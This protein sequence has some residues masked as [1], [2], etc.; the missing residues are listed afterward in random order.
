[1]YKLAH[2]HTHTPTSLSRR[3]RNTCYNI[4]A[5]PLVPVFTPFYFLA[6]HLRRRRLNEDL[7]C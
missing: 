6:T 5:S 1:M 3:W 4:A 7:V 2:T